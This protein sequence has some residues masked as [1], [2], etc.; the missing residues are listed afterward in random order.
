MSGALGADL[1]FKLADP[2]TYLVL[3]SWIDAN[4]AL[5][6]NAANYVQAAGQF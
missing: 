2:N 6:G 5:Q 3:D 4:G 1:L